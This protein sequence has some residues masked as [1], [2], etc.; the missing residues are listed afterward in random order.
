MLLVIMNTKLY[1]S[2]SCQKTTEWLWL[3]IA[4]MYIN[5]L[6]Q[7]LEGAQGSALQKIEGSPLLGTCEILRVKH[8]S[9]MKKLRFPS[10]P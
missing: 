6:Q 8:K 10:F 3:W 1:G 2:Q 7:N 4:I 9:F 5:F